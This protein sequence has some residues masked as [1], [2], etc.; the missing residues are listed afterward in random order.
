MV[1]GENCH[2]GAA[3]GAVLGAAS[4]QGKSEK[5]KDVWKS[6]LTLHKELQKLEASFLASEPNQES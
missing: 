4:R 3:L 2:R 6:G 5:I 1:A